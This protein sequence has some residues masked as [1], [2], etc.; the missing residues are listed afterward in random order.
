MAQ[1]VRIVFFGTPEFAVPSLRALLT[2]RHAVVGVVCQPDRPAGRGQQPA[3]P[4]VK[5]Q[6]ADA[7][8]PVLQPEKVRTAEFLGALR[9][10]TP[11][12][13]VVAA[14]GRILPATI[15]ALPPRGCINVHASLLPK[16]RGAAPVQWAILRGESTT[17]ITIMQMVE[18]MDAGAI[19]LQ[20]A[21]AIGPAETGGELQK[22]LAQL[23]AQLLLE[24]LDRLEAGALQPAPQ[25]EAAVTYAPMI[26]KQD[27]H[28]DW[29]QPALQISRAVRAFN[30]WPSAFTTLG[31]KMLKIHD[32]RAMT[33]DPVAVPG[34][35]LAVADGLTIATG[36]GYLVV[37][38]LQIEGRKRLPAPDFVRGGQ[39]TVGT[40]LGT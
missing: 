32:A 10:W 17:G 37:E 29:Q 24:A 19:L 2:G 30:P 16:Y 14:Y 4:P 3:V 11:E 20:R 25:D 38:E 1:R 35:V 34:T 39:V 23:G 40:V 18:E 8:I 22:R 36:S 28:I 13:I 21:A 7:A 12:L 27:G 15:L 6:A 31:G 33:G 5:R 9:A 26:R